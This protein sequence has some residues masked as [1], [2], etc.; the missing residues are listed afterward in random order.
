MRQ[1]LL[2]LLPPLRERFGITYAELYDMPADERDALI[3]HAHK[4]P[5][6]SQGGD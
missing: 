3:S 5:R 2:E 4:F 1:W 6:Y